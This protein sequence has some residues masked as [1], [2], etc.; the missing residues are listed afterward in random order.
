MGEGS[1]QLDRFRN[2]SLGK[3]RPLQA[4]LELTYRCNER[5]THCYIDRFVDDKTRTLSL[6]QWYKV[7]D[8][9]RSAGVLYLVLMGGEAMLSPHFHDIA[10]RGSELGFHVSMISNGLKIDSLEAAEKLRDSG[11]CLVS[12]SLYSLNPIVHDRMTRVPGSLERLLKAIEFCDQVGVRPTINV[13]LTEA[14][15][16]DVFDIYEWGAAREYEVKVDPTVTPKLSGNLEPTRYRAT[17]ETLLWFYR[18]KARRWPAGAPA[19]YGEA[20]SNYVCNAAKGKCAVNPYGEL[21][22]C[23]E[24]RKPLGSLVRQSFSEIWGTEKV[25]SFR[26]MKVGELKNTGGLAT[27]SFCDHCPGMALHEHGDAR[28]VTNF[29]LMLSQVK[30]QVAKECRKKSEGVQEDKLNRSESVAVKS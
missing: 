17:K 9:L 1:S 20:E 8:E 21:L 4:A 13:L 6:Q 22:P 11:V 19:S 29:S 15:A 16:K 26:T 7:L 18:E 10:K 2:R 12:F 30:K 25:A 24:I 5:C 23:I 28:K 27:Y 14:N 3:M